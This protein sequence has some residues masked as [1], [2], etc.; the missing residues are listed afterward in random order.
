MLVKSEMKAESEGNKKSNEPAAERRKKNART[1][2]SAA[3]ERFSSELGEPRW[4]VVSFENRV[5]RGLTYNQAAAELKKLAA[6]KI[7]GLCIVTDEAGEK[8][9][10]KK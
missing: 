8:V 1:K 3:A 9:E 6:K 10:S 7:S 2:K 4:S 5:A